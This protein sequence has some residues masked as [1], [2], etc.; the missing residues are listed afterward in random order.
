MVPAGRYFAMAR[1]LGTPA[2]TVDEL[3]GAPENVRLRAD[4]ELAAIHGVTL[5]PAARGG[6]GTAPTVDAAT[7]G[8]VTERDGCVEFV[9]AAAGPAEPVPALDLT[10]PDGGLVITGA[11]TVAV[12]RFAD[13]FPQDPIGR[14]RARRLGPARHPRR[15]RLAAVARARDAGGADHGVRPVTRRALVAFA[16]ACLLA[17]PTVL[18]FFSGGYFAQPR[19]I[20]AIVV[21]ALVLALAVAG[22]RRSRGARRA[23]WRWPGSWP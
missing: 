23:A 4:E 13:G 18:A 15:P 6:S 21:W 16:G 22:R 2:A 19:L 12:R 3:A 5:Q 9:P 17:A 14:D 20:A 8:E 10:V 7:G 11:A 1:D